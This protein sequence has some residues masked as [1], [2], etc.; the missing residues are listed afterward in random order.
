MKGEWLGGQVNEWSGDRVTGWTADRRKTLTNCQ[1]DI[2]R[3]CCGLWH[4]H[5]ASKL[6]QAAAL[7]LKA[8]CRRQDQVVVEDGARTHGKVHLRQEHL[9]NWNITNSSGSAI[10]C[11][12]FVRL[13]E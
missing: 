12:D 11:G 8:V 10:D 6:S 2:V 7:L 3:L 9:M 5:A 4:V 13:F 1:T